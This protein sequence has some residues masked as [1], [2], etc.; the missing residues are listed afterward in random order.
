MEKEKNMIG[1]FLFGGEYL[2][3]KKWNGNYKGYKLK[4]GKGIIREYCINE[5]I[6]KG[7]YLNGEKN[8]KGEEYDEQGELIFEGE[9][10]NGKRNGKGK[11]YS[12]VFGN[13]LIFEGEYLYGYRRKG[14]EYIQGILMYEGE[15]ILGKKWEGKGY[16]KDG[17]ISYEIKNGN[18]TIKEYVG[19]YGKLILLYESEYLN[20]EVS[21]KGKQYKENGK[22]IF[23]GEF[24]NSRRNGKGREY[25]YDGNIIF[26][27]EYLNDERWNGKGKKYDYS[28]GLDIEI[29]YVNGKEI[30]KV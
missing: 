15:Y 22:L 20:G 30:E 13:D 3:G 23:E 6:F 29:E 9:Y 2:K 19:F 4:N 24:L 1:V 16:D 25:D 17:K 7:E 26:E 27:G 10:L 12:N 21:G 18:G 11:E 5:L 28:K 14:K 8:G